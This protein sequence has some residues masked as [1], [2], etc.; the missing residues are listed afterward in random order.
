M[1]ISLYPL[2][3]TVTGAGGGV[4]RILQAM[5]AVTIEKYPLVFVER[6]EPE[7]LIVDDDVNVD[8]DAVIVV[9]D[10]DVT[11]E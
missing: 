3:M 10:D 6:E 1:T 5:Q 9:E 11:V 4:D 7:A 2:Y 8:S